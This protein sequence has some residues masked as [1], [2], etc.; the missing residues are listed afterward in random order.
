VDPGNIV[1]ATDTTGLAV[2]T[3]VQPIAVVF[4]LPEEQLP[5]V[6]KRIK[7][8]GDVL[9]D[10]YSQDMLTKIATGKLLALDSAID[11]TTATIHAKAVF[12]NPDM[13]LYPSQF[14]NARLLVD[15]LKQVVLVPTATVQRSTRGTFV[16]VVKLDD[17]ATTNPSE[18]A[19]GNAATANGSG[20][21]GSGVGAA[22][23]GQPQGMAPAAG[24]SGQSA[25]GASNGKSSG[26]NG[27]TGGAPG[28]AGVVD[29]AD[30]VL[31]PTQGD[32]TVIES[33]VT[34][35]Q[36]VVTDGV[37]KLIKGSKVTVKISSPPSSPSAGDNA[38]LGVA[39]GSGLGAAN[40]VES[41][42]MNS[43]EDGNSG[44]TTRPS[45]RHRR[46]GGANGAGGEQGGNATGGGPGDATQPSNPAEGQ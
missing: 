44:A 15:T 19:G 16:Y 27:G 23:T 9:V 12:A 25:A 45:R 20:G 1:H 17:S 13:S 33:G 26:A 46:A 14:V 39:G 10:A 24:E 28:M 30:V 3:Q 43:S 6:L 22:A 11:S 5:Q 42:G 31:G 21:G 29:M 18:A 8:G 35:G 34:P 32:L 38:G 2:I 7:Q 36:I 40:D 37:D 4:S 41:G